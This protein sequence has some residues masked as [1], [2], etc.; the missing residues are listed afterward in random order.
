[1]WGPPSLPFNGWYR[2][3]FSQEVNVTGVLRARMCGEIPLLSS[4]IYNLHKD[5]N[6]IEY[7][8]I[9]RRGCAGH[10]ISMEDAR[11]K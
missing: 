3:I 10:I 1:L 8:V 4:V 2:G 7:I 5:L 6:I 9:R 11:I